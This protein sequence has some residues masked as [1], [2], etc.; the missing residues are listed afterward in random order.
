[1][2]QQYFSYINGEYSASSILAILMVNISI[3]PY[4][5]GPES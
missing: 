2:S 4:A 3:V 1:L 5:A